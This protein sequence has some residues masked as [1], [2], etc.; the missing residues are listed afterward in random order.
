M[1]RQTENKRQKNQIG[2]TAPQRV[3]GV[4]SSLTL[5]IVATAA[6]GVAFATAIALPLA[7]NAYTR[8]RINWLEEDIDVLVAEID[9]IER[10]LQE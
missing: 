7:L 8:R 3:S 4:R 2:M 5:S 6:A 10:S 9:E 1:N